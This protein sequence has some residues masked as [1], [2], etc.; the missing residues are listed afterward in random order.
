MKKKTRSIVRACTITLS[1][2]AALMCT[3][4]CSGSGVETNS[5]SETVAAGSNTGNGIQVV[6]SLHINNVEFTL[7]ELDIKPMWA[8]AGMPAGEKPFMVLLDFSG[9][10]DA[11]EALTAIYEN[12]SLLVNGEQVVIGTTAYSADGGF[13]TLMSSTSVDL[14]SADLSIELIYGNEKLI[15]V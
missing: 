15:V 5:N 6:Q 14:K 8:P 7:K 3:T 2:L 11:I 9:S 13:V 4:G 10:G 12:A 1:L